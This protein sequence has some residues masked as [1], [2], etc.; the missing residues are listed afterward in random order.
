MIFFDNLKKL[1]TEELLTKSNES[2]SKQEA[3][4]KF[5]EA[6]GDSEINGTVTVN[7]IKTKDGLEIY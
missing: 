5:V 1:F 3:H 2:Y 4:D 7:S 6:E